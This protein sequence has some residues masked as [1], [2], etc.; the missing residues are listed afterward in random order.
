M[1]AT[2]NFFGLQ[3]IGIERSKKRAERAK[4]I[5]I[6]FALETKKYFIKK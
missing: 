5:K 2:A 4:S 1:M 6:D 3:A